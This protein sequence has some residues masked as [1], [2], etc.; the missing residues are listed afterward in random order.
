MKTTKKKQIK[1]L[2]NNNQIF[3]KM[4]GKKI[5]R[6]LIATI[7]GGII[8]VNYDYVIDGDTIKIQGKSVRLFA[9]D[10]PEKKQ[11]CYKDSIAWDCG[12]KAKEVLEEIIKDQKISCIP[13]AKDKYKRT[14]AICFAGSV[15]INQ[16]MVKKGFAVAVPELGGKDYIVYEEYAKKNKLG[17]WQGSFE[18]PS[19]W[20]K[21]QKALQQ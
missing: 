3:K 14:I 12:M 2:N 4:Y 17:I 19:L 7:I 16:E 1:E 11:L 13:K 8:Y 10:A 6:A 9:I 20:R 5:I 21:T 18:L 15:E